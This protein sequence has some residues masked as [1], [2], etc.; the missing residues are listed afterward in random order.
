MERG[1]AIWLIIP[2]TDYWQFALP[3]NLFEGNKNPTRRYKGE[4]GSRATQ[5]RA[6]FV[7][8]GQAASLRAGTA[9]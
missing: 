8:S 6:A 9:D 7:P 3:R 4:P 5:E 2:L 1:W